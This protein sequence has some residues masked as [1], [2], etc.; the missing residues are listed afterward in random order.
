[1]E[2]GVNGFVIPSGD[3]KTMADRIVTI[4]MSGNM[5]L[6]GQKSREKASE[7]FSLPAIMQQYEMFYEGVVKL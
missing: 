3:H 2:D 7:L 1:V 5:A 4:L 6:Q